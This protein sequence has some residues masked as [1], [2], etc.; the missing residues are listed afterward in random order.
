MAGLTEGKEIVRDLDDAIGGEF[1]QT[2]W[3]QL[4]LLWVDPT[5]LD[6]VLEALQEKAP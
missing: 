6:E 2:F 1:Q 4:K 3:D 5:T